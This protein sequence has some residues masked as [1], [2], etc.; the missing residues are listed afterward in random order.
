MR[1]N[2]VSSGQQVIEALELA[3]RSA[4]QK[5]VFQNILQ[6]D[7]L[8]VIGSNTQLISLFCPKA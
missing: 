5:G 4:F 1:Y 6:V 8:S 7:M 3:L 2:K